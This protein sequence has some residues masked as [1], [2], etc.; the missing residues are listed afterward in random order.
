MCVKLPLG[1]LNSDFYPLLWSDN[2][3]K[4]VYWYHTLKIKKKKKKKGSKVKIEFK[5]K[6]I[7]VETL[8]IIT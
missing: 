6:I 4:G 2:R 3:T 7:Y 1:D 5:F 8:N